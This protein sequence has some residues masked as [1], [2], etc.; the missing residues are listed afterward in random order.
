[1]KEKIFNNISLKILSIIFA[2]ILWGLIVNI[3]DPT[4]G[5]TITGVSVQLINTESLSSQNYTYEV[6]DGSKISVYVSG[7]TSVITNIKASDIVATADLSNISAFADYVDIDV[8][9]V[10][11]GQTLQNVE[12]TPKTTAVKLN[13]ES[14]VTQSFDVNMDITGNSGYVLVNQI[15]TPSF[16]KVKGP[17][18]EIARVAQVKAVYDIS[19]VTSSIS[20]TASVAL[21]DAE[22]N[23]I[24]DSG[25]E[26][27]Q[28]T[29]AFS[30]SL[31]LSKTVDVNYATSGTPAAGYSVARIEPS[32]TQVTLTGNANVV[33]Q[34][35]S[36]DIPA[37]VLNV[38]GSNRDRN[39]RIWLSDYVPEQVKVTSENF[40]NI[41]VRITG[42]SSQSITISSSDIQLNNIPS[43]MT[44][45]IISM[46]NYNI[47]VQGPH[48]L[49]GGLTVSDIRPYVDLSGMTEGQREVTVQYQL[50]NGITVTGNSTVTINIKA[51]QQESS[52][53]SSTQQSTAAVN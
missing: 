9:V 28:N 33:E 14:S 5:F 35:N 45:E 21:Y 19:G 10:K 26:L 51:A 37:S 46:D 44:A 49:V 12:V 42:E 24:T 7:P 23:E 13:I 2:I 32:V 17:A 1:M 25:L 50:G 34:I 22:G 53:E 18:S 11:D 31:G 27:S 38:D 39:Y 15:V 4:T 30:A 52:N 8:K 40:V 6:V 36:L 20:D 29:V 41:D 48:S 43:G 3:Y 16:I 47:A